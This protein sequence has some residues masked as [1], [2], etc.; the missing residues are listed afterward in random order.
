[1]GCQFKVRILQA[2]I[3]KTNYHSD[4]VMVCVLAVSWVDRWV[5]PRSG[6]AKYYK[7]GI[8]CFCV[9]QVLMQHL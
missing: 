8:C 9:K 1:M 3:Q 6:Q 7:I 2:F 5:E 4:D